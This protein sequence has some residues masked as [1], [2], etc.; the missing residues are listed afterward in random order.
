MCMTLTKA[1]AGSGAEYETSGKPEPN[2]LVQA[3]Q[4]CRDRKGR[5]EEVI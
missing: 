3:P 4:H 1:G 5:W 2:R